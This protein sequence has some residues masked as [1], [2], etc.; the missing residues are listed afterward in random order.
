MNLMRM[1]I[2]GLAGALTLTGAHQVL[3]R[4]NPDAP[5]LDSLGMQSIDKLM[6][7]VG[8][9]PLSGRP[10]FQSALAGDLVSNSLYYSQVG[11]ASGSGT[12][13][14]GIILGLT[15]GYGAVKLPA[16][17]GLNS[18]ASSRTKETELMTVGLY[19]LGGLAAA[20]AAQLLCNDDKSK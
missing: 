8:M 17:L 3:K 6:S 9:E 5:H 2:S 14:R 13:I 18:A 4:Y 15:A 19:L 11:S 16:K 10:L 1:A 7:A 12:W 20:A